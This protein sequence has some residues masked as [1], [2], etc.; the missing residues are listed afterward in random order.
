MQG[1]AF[2][3]G[4]WNQVGTS[5]EGL[6]G[7]ARTR[8]LEPKIQISNLAPTSNS[9]LKASLRAFLGA[10]SWGEKGANFGDESSQVQVHI[11]PHFPLNP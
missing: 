9:K 3:E 7:K 8:G 11:H 1:R 2:L 6:G 4:K 5:K 10:Q